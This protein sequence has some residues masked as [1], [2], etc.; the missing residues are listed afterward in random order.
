METY[1]ICHRSGAVL[2]VSSLAGYDPSP[3]SLR[4]GFYL[5]IIVYYNYIRQ[6]ERTV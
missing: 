3:V 5:L 1:S 4:Q 6:L 2:F